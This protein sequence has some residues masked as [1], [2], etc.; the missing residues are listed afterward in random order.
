MIL[1]ETTKTCPVSLLVRYASDY[2]GDSST[3]PIPKVILEAKDR[4]IS[5]IESRN[6]QN[7]AEIAIIDVIEKLVPILKN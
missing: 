5:L 2:Q 7:K 1:K 4:T 6:D 3:T